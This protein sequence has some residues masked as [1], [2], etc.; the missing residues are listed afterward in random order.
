[1]NELAETYNLRRFEQAFKKLG[2][3]KEHNLKIFKMLDQ[4]FSEKFFRLEGGFY[5]T[6]ASLPALTRESIDIPFQGTNLKDKGAINF[7]NQTT[8]SFRN[9][10]Y[11]GLRSIFED[12]MFGDGNPLD[13]SAKYCVGEDSTIQYVV[14]DSKNRI[15]RGYEFIGAYITNVGETSYNNE[16]V[17]ITTTDVTFDFS[18]WR[19]LSLDGFDLDQFAGTG[20]DSDS[21]NTN[22]SVIYQDLYDR[23][24]EKLND[25]N[26]T[27]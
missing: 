14:V 3:S 23:I 17:Q 12:R 26:T 1:M 2:T 9:D 11:L 7:G 5:V 18:Y 6:T 24:D 10:S 16:G 4:E 19:P 22:Q 21:A 15:T 8:I 25:A 20:N 27:C 13:G